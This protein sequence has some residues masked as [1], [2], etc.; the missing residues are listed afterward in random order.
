VG[1][2][3]KAGIAELFPSMVTASKLVCFGFKVFGF[4][5]LRNKSVKVYKDCKIV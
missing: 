4:M 1:F 3:S 2:L 5:F